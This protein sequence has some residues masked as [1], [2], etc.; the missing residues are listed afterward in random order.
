[1][2]PEQIAPVILFAILVAG[3]LYFILRPLG[4]SAAR[5]RARAEARR[6]QLLER[7]NVF[8]QLLRDLEFDRKTGKL[9]EDDF[10]SAREDA[11]TGALAVLRELDALNQPWSKNRIEEEIASVRARLQTGGRR[12]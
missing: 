2:G 4:S 9:S 1:M 6:I 12:A 5:E 3:A 7:K 8:V 10:A 11:E